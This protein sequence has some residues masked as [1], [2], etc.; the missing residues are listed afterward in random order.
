MITQI[1]STC[2]FSFDS[3][4]FLPSSSFTVSDMWIYIRDVSFFAV[5]SLLRYTFKHKIFP[6]IYYVLYKTIISNPAKYSIRV[7][8]YNVGFTARRDGLFFYFLLTAMIEKHADSLE[9]QF[10]QPRMC[11]ILC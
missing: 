3:T 9:I 6:F 1:S 10:I 7:T 11:G 5:C 8:F 2:I 4:C